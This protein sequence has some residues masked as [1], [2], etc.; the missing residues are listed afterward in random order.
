MTFIRFFLIAIIVFSLSCKSRKAPQSI[1]SITWISSC[2]DSLNHVTTEPILIEYYENDTLKSEISF[3]KRGAK[4]MER[5]TYYD[6][7]GREIK[8]ELYVGSNIIDGTI[9]YRD[10]A[11]NIIKSKMY[12]GKYGSDT[13]TFLYVNK[14][15][16]DSSE[17]ESEIYLEGK[18]QSVV[19][20]VYE[21]TILRQVETFALRGDSMLLQSTEKYAYDHQGYKTEELI[22]SPDGDISSKTVYK[23]NKANLTSKVVYREGKPVFEITFF[24]KHG[25][26]DYAVKYDH[27]TGQQCRITFVY[28]YL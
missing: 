9:I 17:M 20:F 27:L 10:N 21:K 24:Y 2:T 13:L 4:T 23:Y 16:E 7:K 15:N 11:G 8:K 25:Q 19:K 5:R 14:F 3:E 22:Q 28:Q 18:L 26:K 1:T 6:Q 12:D